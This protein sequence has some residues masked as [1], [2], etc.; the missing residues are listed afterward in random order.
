MVWLNLDGAGEAECRPAQ[1][2]GADDAGGGGVWGG[3]DEE[4]GVMVT[5]SVEAWRGTHGLAPAVENGGLRWG[6]GARA[7]LR[8]A[9]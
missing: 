2:F 8:P 1:S 9:M 3:G 5:G 4:K 6:A 7:A